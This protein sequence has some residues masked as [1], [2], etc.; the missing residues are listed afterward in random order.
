MRATASLSLPLW[1]A[2][3]LGSTLFGS[4]LLAQNAR[5]PQNPPDQPWRLDAWLGTPDYLRVSGSHRTRFESLNGQFRTGSTRNTEDQVFHRTLLR[6]DYSRMAWSATLEGIDARAHNT[7]ADSFANTTTV[8]TFDVLQASIGY[9]FGDGHRVTAGR[10]TMDLGSRRLIARNKYRNTINSFN[11][12]RWDYANKQEGYEAGA[13]WSL[14]TMR[15]PTDPMQLVDNEHDWDN[16]T[17]D[18]QFFGVHAQTR[19]DEGSTG[20]VY[21][22]GTDNSS[23]SNDENLWTA[24]FRY[25]RP[26]TR[27]NVS[28][29]VE[30][31]YQFG[32]RGSDDVNAW[33]LHGSAGYT[34]DCDLQPSVRAAIDI[35][36]GNDSSSDYTR[37]NTLYG[38]RRFEY[39]PT[40]IYG[41]I[42]RRNIISP[43]V[44]FSLKPCPA[45]W[46]MVGWR[47]IRLE[48][49][50]DAWAEA[51]DNS[52][53]GRHVGSQV[54]CRL[55]WD[56]C[57]GNLRFETG[58]VYLTGGNFRETSES[59]RK[60]D[61]RYFYFETIL[62][63]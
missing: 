36:T 37:F 24:G 48:D 26:P 59:G 49:G 25:F 61:T 12:V 34:W 57:P 29:E 4:T 19:I 6:A 54:E 41:A 2:T 23:G 32:E 22:L 53:S 63:F 43:E 40:G 30:A 14:P 50:N 16:Q 10:W 62:T 9:A 46:V 42:G 55:R 52:G 27:G 20:Q 60:T 15:R 56:A 38:A 35:A 18:V 39:G 58:G 3:L 28:G 31:A 13:F 33:F 8:N 44:R 51:G 17:T 5:S 11:G 7:K 1:T 21:L 47:D 45:T